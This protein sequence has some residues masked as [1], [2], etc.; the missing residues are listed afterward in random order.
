MHSA[1][2]PYKRPQRFSAD[3]SSFFHAQE[4]EA[5]KSESHNSS[6]FYTHL[7]RIHVPMFRGKSFNCDRPAIESIPPQLQTFKQEQ[8][9]SIYQLD[10]QSVI[11]TSIVALNQAAITVLT[12]ETNVMNILKKNGPI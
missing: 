6:N 10:I 7:S 5:T 11:A 9:H 4:L 3:S 1:S 2:L 8:I 12:H